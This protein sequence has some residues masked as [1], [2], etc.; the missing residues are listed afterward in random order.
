MLMKVITKCLMSFVLLIKSEHNCRN[1]D[2][3]FSSFVLQF[4]RLNRY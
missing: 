1:V 4:L 2:S 3:S